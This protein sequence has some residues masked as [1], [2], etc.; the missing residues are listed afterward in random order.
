MQSGFRKGHS[1]TTALG[2]VVDNI[3]FAQD[4]GEITALVLLDY[5]RAFDT[6]NIPLL[7]SKMKYYGFTDNCVSWFDS[8]LKNR[9]QIVELVDDDGTLTRSNAHYV[10][11][12]VPQG[13]VLGPLIFSLYT[14][15]V[16][17]QI[18]H[19]C[20]HMYADDIQVYASFSPDNMTEVISKLNEDLAR[21]SE[22]SEA[23]ALV[24]NPGKTK[25]MLMGTKAQINKIAN[26]M[27]P[28]HI[29]GNLIETVPETRNLGLL[30]DEGMRF[31][32][33][34]VKTV[35]NCFYRLKILY[36]IRRFISTDLR[37]KLR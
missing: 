27:P 30:M 12:G 26:V 15:D 25:Y 8:Y 31:E 16:I 13:S 4:R 32:K 35:S 10:N 9:H 7:L 23:N 21:I 24:L 18:Q 20:Y 1:T 3:L 2:D 14:A 5:S 11:R 17:K 22:W 19:S 33:H 29:K 28:I 37:I 36:K 34:I 6:L